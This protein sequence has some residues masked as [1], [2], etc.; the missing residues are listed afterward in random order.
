MESRIR[1][2]IKFLLRDFIFITGWV[3]YENEPDIHKLSLNGKKICSVG[4]SKLGGTFVFDIEQTC[5]KEI[6]QILVKYK[7]LIKDL[8][9]A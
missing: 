9:C 1:N 6:K 4:R 5:P 2:E 7:D 3:R 8:E